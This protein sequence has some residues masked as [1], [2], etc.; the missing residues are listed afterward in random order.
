[1]TYEGI[2][3]SKSLRVCFPTAFPLISWHYSIFHTQEPF[4]PLDARNLQIEF[5]SN[6]LRGK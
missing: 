4:E 3:L 2:P 1:M 6:H 5:P